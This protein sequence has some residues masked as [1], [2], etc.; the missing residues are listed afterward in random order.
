M[1][2]VTAILLAVF[3]GSIPALANSPLDPREM[4]PS[5]DPLIEGEDQNNSGKP[6]PESHPIEAE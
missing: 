2:Y 6:A 3:G 1:M 4:E 5:V